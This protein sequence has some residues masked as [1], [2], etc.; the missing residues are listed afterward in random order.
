[1]ILG[2]IITVSHDRYFL[3]R[4][5]DKVFVHQEDGTFKQYSGGYS[6][7]LVKSK[8]ENKKGLLFKS[9]IE[10]KKRSQ[11]SYM[12]KRNWSNYLRRWKY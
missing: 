1:M 7:Y 10:K 4:V 12:E 6:D 3:D 9:R 5:V 2:A 8:D 11:L